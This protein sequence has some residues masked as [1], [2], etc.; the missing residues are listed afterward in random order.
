[1]PY[2]VEHRSEAWKERYLRSLGGRSYQQ[3]LR[4]L[5]PREG[6]LFEMNHYG[7]WTIESM[8][9][10]N[11]A[12]PN[13]LEL[14]F[15]TLRSDFDATFTQMFDRFGL[16]PAERSTALGIAAKEDLG[17]MTRE[18]IQAIDHVTSPDAEKW[19]EH[20]E[21]IHHRTFQQRFGDALVRL[22]YESSPA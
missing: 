11:Y 10:W 2:V 20:F 15:E 17:R 8:L 5:G 16:T 21:A 1:V 3:M 13:V 4:T 7:S 22:G 19:R 9:D 18:Q 12:R 14:R 6:L